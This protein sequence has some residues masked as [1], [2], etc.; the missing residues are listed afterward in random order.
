MKLKHLNRHDQDAEIA[1]WLESHPEPNKVI[2]EIF[3]DFDNLKDHFIDWLTYAEAADWAFALIR[4]DLIDIIE[5]E[6]PPA[7]YTGNISEVI[8]QAT[9]DDIEGRKK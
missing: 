1:K 7:P 6:D 4:S 5:S 8:V 3:Q 9:K 2:C